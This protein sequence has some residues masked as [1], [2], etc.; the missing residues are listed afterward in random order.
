MLPSESR[1]SDQTEC[2]LHTKYLVRLADA[3]REQ[4]AELTRTGKA[5]A[6]KSRH[7]QIRVKADADGPAWTEARIAESFSVRGN[8]VLSVR[9][10]VVEQGREAAR[11][12]KTQAH[13]ARGP[14][15]DGAGAARLI[16]LRCSAPPPGQARWT[17]RL[18]ADPAGV[19]AMVEAI[20]HET[21]RPTRQNMR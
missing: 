5:A 20:S 8:T 13:P 21:L 7:A 4:V 19:L 6:S 16:A 15:V 9:Q 11:N 10:R 14:L 2:A 1:M 17:L 3:A 12:R 18:W